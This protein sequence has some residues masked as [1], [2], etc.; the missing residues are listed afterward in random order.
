MSD[1]ALYEQIECYLAKQ[2]DERERSTFEL[3]RKSDAEMDMQIVEHMQFLHALNEQSEQVLLRNKFNHFHAQLDVEAIRDEVEEKPSG[4]VRLW[5]AHHSKISVAAS[6]AILA[7]LSTLF[8]TGYFGNQNHQTTYSALR[9]DIQKIKQSQNALIRNVKGD[10]STVKVDEGEQFGGTGFALSGNG[11]IV[12]N[13]HVIN[14]ADSISVQNAAGTVYKARAIY[15]DPSVDIAVL[16]ITDTAFRNLE[17]VPYT[18]KKSNSELGEDVYT[19]GYP[20]DEIVLGKGYLSSATGYNGDTIAYQVSIPVN[21]G[22]SGGP[23]MDSKGNVIGLINGKQTQ[24]DGAA[25]AIKSNYLLKAIQ[26][27]PSDSLSNKLELN[28][29]NHLSGISR[30]E[31]IKKMQNYIYMVRVYNKN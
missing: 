2:M 22:N 6:V 9:R 25:F 5:R 14:G 30:A 8:Y 3:M 29:R 10:N 24:V 13:Y 1:L 26:A 12:T 4:I 17:P 15:V 19:I 23:L 18:F 21:P 31:Q 20:R 11:Y 28:T 7:V 27:I 16:Q